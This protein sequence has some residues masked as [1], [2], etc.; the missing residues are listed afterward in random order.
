MRRLAQVVAVVTVAL[1]AWQAVTA[2]RIARAGGC[3]FDGEQYCAAARG[4]RIDAPYSRRPL[5]PHLVRLLHLG[6]VLDRFVVVDLVALAVAAVLAGVL[7][8]RLSGSVDAAVVAGCLLLLQPLTVHAALTYPAATDPVALALLLGWL[9]LY[10][11]ERPWW[12]LPVA[13]LA[14][15]AREALGPVVLAVVVADVVTSRPRWRLAVATAAAVVTAVAYDYAVPSAGRGLTTA[16]VLRTWLRM[17]FGSVG[18]GARLAWM[19]LTGLGL[20][21]LLL[22]A[23]NAWRVPRRPLVLLGTAAAVNAVLAV[24][25]GNDTAR[26]LLPTLAVVIV[27]APAYAAREP[28]VVPVL[29]VLVA[30]T[31]LLWRPWLVSPG[32][33]AAFLRYYTPYYSGAAAFT[34]RFV[35][36]GAVAVTTVACAAMV[37]RWRGSAG[38]RAG[39]RGR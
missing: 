29:A 35:L 4:L 26:L 2:E 23:R 32:E 7:V 34:R 36:D 38:S 20:V 37:A 39:R 3:G 14:C 22:L 8:V 30:G 25:G 18:G 33:T 5:V 31:V 1:L 12:G 19:V 27:L 21:P 9:V 17:H 28:R 13:V 11:F 10:A 24:A 6:S 15:L 16:Q